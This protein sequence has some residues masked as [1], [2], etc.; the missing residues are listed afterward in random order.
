MQRFD[1]I[2]IGAGIAGTMAAETIRA[3]DASATICIVGDEPHRL[4]SRVL[5]P[6]VVRGKSSEEKAFLRTEASYEE[7][8][9]AFR[10]GVAVASVDPAAHVVRFA[11]GSEASY[12]KALLI[13]T[14]GSVR[15]LSC[16]GADEADVMY[17]QTLDDAQRIVATSA[18]TALVCGGGFIALELLMSF[19][20]MGVPAIV[21][22]RGKGFFSR[23]LDP[24]GAEMIADEVAK[25]GIQVRTATEVVAIERVQGMKKA[26]LTSGESVICDAVSAGLGIIPNV[27]FLA[28]SGIDIATGVLA[29]SHLRASSPGVFAAGDVAESPDPFTGERRITGNWQNAMFQG[30][31]AGANMAGADDEYAMLTAYSITCF[32]LPIAFVGAT[33]GSADERIVRETMQGS[34][35]LF[36]KQGRCVG[37]TS[38]G[39][40][41]DR[42]TVTKLI[43]GRVAFTD[44]MREAVRDGRTD[45]AGFL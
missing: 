14:G 19:A 27:G 22:M 33:D 45:L 8:Q 24:R 44:L 21:V 18:R 12:D 26:F 17:F 23:V 2:I 11:D 39:P 15:K 16:P 1:H 40:F 3:R 34:L 35:Q 5:L 9:F 38:V 30:K 36:L 42:A 28:G 37:A 41:S 31:I 32:D 43:N 25:H 20:H 29:D 7:K 6:H 13:A 4:Y 10:K